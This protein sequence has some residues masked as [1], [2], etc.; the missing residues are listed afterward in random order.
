VLQNDVND[1]VCNIEA[2]HS[3]NDDDDLVVDHIENDLD[4]A[5]M[6]IEA[7]RLMH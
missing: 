3:S 5:S 1:A 6:D 7:H 2:G 4:W